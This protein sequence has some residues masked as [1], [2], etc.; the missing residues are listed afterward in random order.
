MLGLI[1]LCRSQQICHRDL[2]LENTLLDGSPTPQLKICD[3]GYSKVD[4]LS[5]NKLESVSFCHIFSLF[6]LF[7]PLQSGLLHSQPKSTVGT[8]A[9]IAPEV[10]SRK[11]Y[12]GKVF[13]MW[14]TLLQAAA[15][16]DD[17]VTPCRYQMF[18]HVEL[19]CM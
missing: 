15:V 3:F 12:D 7:D 18:G 5:S 11:E 10:L 8:P 14:Y 9:Y 16:L 13:S 4:N 6:C 2:K 19:H 1:V 17:F